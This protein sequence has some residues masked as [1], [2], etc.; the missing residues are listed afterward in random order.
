MR[1]YSLVCCS[2]GMMHVGDQVCSFRPWEALITL[3][4]SCRAPRLAQYVEAVRDA[5]SALC[6]NCHPGQGGRP[7]TQPGFRL[8]LLTG[9]SISGNSSACQIHISFL[10]STS[11]T[12]PSHCPSFTPHSYKLWVSAEIGTLYT[13]L[14]IHPYRLS[15]SYFYTDFW[16]SHDFKQSQEI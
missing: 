5:I 10:F 16:K 7:Q 14:V 8:R 12:K 15:T 9:C 11:A 2:T 6:R 3:F 1:S 13:L 4:D